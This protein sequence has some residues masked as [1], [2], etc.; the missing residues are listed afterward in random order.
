MS[1][2]ARKFPRRS[3][4]SPVGCLS[5]GNYHVAQ[6]NQLGE[7]G[8]LVESEFVMAIG[9]TIVMTLKIPGGQFFCGRGQILYTKKSS[10]S[11]FMLYGCRFN[12]LHLDVKRSI[13]AFV[14]DKTE[15]EAKNDL[16]FH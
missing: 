7:G 2:E 16:D 8:C 5:H 3:L 11:G 6:L 1:L 15:I 9:D 14:A 10:N 12:E 4:V 13:R